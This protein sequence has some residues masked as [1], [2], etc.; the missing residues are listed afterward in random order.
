[1]LQVGSQQTH[2][3]ELTQVSDSGKCA[4]LTTLQRQ[5]QRARPKPLALQVGSQQTHPD[6]LTQVSDSG[7]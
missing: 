3:D 7:K 2:P 5:G 4:Q 6:E 1:M